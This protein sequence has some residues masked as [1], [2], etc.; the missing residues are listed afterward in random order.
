MEGDIIIIIEP[1]HVQLPTLAKVR[2]V[3]SLI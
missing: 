3:F 1:A 2:G